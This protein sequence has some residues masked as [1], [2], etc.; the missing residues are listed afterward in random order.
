[1]NGYTL[2]DYWFILYRRKKT[3][4]LI[5]FF[6]VVFAA[7]LSWLLPK[8]YQ[9]KSVFFVPSK[10][11]SLTFFSNTDTR[12]IARFPLV[13]E[14]RGE[15]QKIYLGMLDSES[16]RKKINA[17][18]SQKSLHELKKDVDFKSGSDFLIEVYVRDHNPKQAADIANAYVRLF[19]QTLS[20]Y[21]LSITVENRKAMQRQLQETQ[22]KLEVAR[23]ALADF[24]RENKLT[25]IDEDSGNVIKL[26]NEFEKEFSETEVKLH[27]ATKKLQ[28]LK[29]QFS[30]ESAVFNKSAVALTSALVENLQKQLSDLEGQIASA[31]VKYTDDHQEVLSLRAQYEQKKK[32]LSDEINQLMESR[33]KSPNSFLE[34]LRQ[35]MVRLYVEKET[36]QSRL[37]G[38]KKGIKDANQQ[39]ALLPIVQA[40][41]EELNQEVEQYK[42]LSENL[43]TGLEEIAAQEQREMKNVIV[44]DEATPPEVPVFPNLIL[45]LFVALGMGLVGGV[46]YT[47]FMDYLDR[48]KLNLEEDIK[49]LERE[50]I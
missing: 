47:Y 5:I 48:L 25:K 4:F 42:K 33:A 9:A 35:E 31:R 24:Q 11:D 19:N 13:P 46:F 1:M 14:A 30:K 29:T 12:Q 6:S 3:V 18:F 17:D 20:S 2:Y 26:K 28:S 21:S 15:Q 22:Q 23:S 38:L 49:E 36:L 45:N 40:R 50:Y 32:D 37:D 39:I 43:Q 27:E 34:N 16:L 7:I 8:V 10:S 44:V 41:Y